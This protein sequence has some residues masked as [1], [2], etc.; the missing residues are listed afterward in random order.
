MALALADT[1]VGSVALDVRWNTPT[2]DPSRFPSQPQ[3]PAIIHY[4]QQVDRQGRILPTGVGPLDRRI[5]LANGAIDHLWPDGFPDSTYQKWLKL[6]GPEP[7]EAA[8]S[9]AGWALW[10]QEGPTVSCRSHGAAPAVSEVTTPDGRATFIPS[11]TA[12]QDRGDRPLLGGGLIGGCRLSRGSRQ[13]GGSRSL[14]DLGSGGNV[15]RNRS[16]SAGGQGPLVGA[17]DA[18]EQIPGSDEGDDGDQHC[19]GS[20]LP[21]V[22]S[23]VVTTH[24]GRHGVNRNRKV[25]GSYQRRNDADNY[26]ND[27]PEPFHTNDCSEKRATVHSLFADHHAPS[28]TCS[29][30]VGSTCNT[31]SREPRAVGQTADGRH[32]HRQWHGH[33]P[34]LAGPQPDT[35]RTGRP[36]LRR[37]PKTGRLG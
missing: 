14:G 28:S 24:P 26:Q 5:A 27:H 15:N 11:A 17:A 8:R 13:F 22:T 35:H 25:L 34:H 19:G 30:I 32:N 33:G 29:A 3:E 37:S 36:P 31:I 2:H 10:A 20:A 21:V 12:G 9:Q 18:E 1:G 6:L 4:H 23:A 16:R 7:T